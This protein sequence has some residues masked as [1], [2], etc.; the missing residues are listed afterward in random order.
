MTGFDSQ[1]DYE[2]LGQFRGYPIYAATVCALVHGAALV[3]CCLFAGFGG[4]ELVIALP[5]NTE[6]VLSKFHFW[7]VVTYALFHLPKEGWDAI[8]LA[9]E[10]LML[11]S[12]GREVERFM[13]R[14][15]FWYLYGALWLA[16]PVALLLASYFLGAMAFAGSWILHLS[17]FLAFAIIYPNT[18]FWWLP[19]KWVAA[20]VLAANT[21]AAI[22]WH[23]IPM[24]IALW[25]SA[26]LAYF[27]VRRAGVGDGFDVMAAIRER[28]ARRPAAAAPRSKLKVLPDPQPEVDATMDSV[29]SVLEKISKH[30][31]GSLTSSERA[32]LERARTTLLNRGKKDS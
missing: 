10:L 23:Q 22:A 25:T 3:L 18:E 6:A 30:G 14:R 12:L 28:F 32:T 27:A 9:V 11:A 26:G 5:L 7:Q 2:P 19:A 1:D 17:F 16:T 8:W 31:I 15:F 29:D 13:G 20:I 21:L 24:L 4:R